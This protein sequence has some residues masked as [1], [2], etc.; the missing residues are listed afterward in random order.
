MIIA[1]QGKCDLVSWLVTSKSA[2]RAFFLG[3]SVSDDC[4]CFRCMNR[5]IYF[6]R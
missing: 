6:L 4:Y 2:R 3:C 1:P 5:T